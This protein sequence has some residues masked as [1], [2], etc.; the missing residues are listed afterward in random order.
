[1]APGAIAAT[2]MP[3]PSGPLEASDRDA[4]EAHRA[5]VARSVAPPHPQAEFGQWE[6]GRQFGAPVPA[7]P[8]P[9]ARAPQPPTAP[10]LA[11]Q[12]GAQPAP[13]A[14]QPR[15][16]PARPAR[17]LP[18]PTPGSSAAGSEDQDWTG[19]AQRANLLRPGDA[20]HPISATIGGMTT[21][22][23]PPDRAAL[24]GRLV[25]DMTGAGAPSWA[26]RQGLQLRGLP[27]PEGTDAELK[28]QAGREYTAVYNEGVRR[29]QA[30]NGG[31]LVPPEVDR[32]ITKETSQ[33]VGYLPEM[34]KR[35]E[36]PTA[37]DEHAAALR[38]AETSLGQGKPFKT[39]VA[40]VRD[41]GLALRPAD[42]DLLGRR[43]Y[44]RAYTELT[45][46]G[47]PHEQAV[48]AAIAEVGDPTLAPES[49]RARAH[50]DAAVPK[51][52]A[53]QMILEGQRVPA[54]GGAGTE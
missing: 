36:M 13:A 14:Q 26:I 49:D 5:M 46:G 33:Y 42:R 25:E 39:V 48:L 18:T 6:Q 11:P 12:A 15:P 10:G 38:M 22:R 31:R 17:P 32:K 23:T 50:A 41:F 40:E 54:K 9:A 45:R 24:A 27:T 43:E 52:V 34:Y 1:M 20:K 37:D 28:A 47:T 44:G 8:E 51:D 53:E 19:Y 16:A 21:T 2:T 4:L 29:W 7:A 3:P 30:D 35:A